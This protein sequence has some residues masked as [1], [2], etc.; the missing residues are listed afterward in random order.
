MLRTHQALIK[1]ENSSKTNVSIGDIIRSKVKEIGFDASKAEQL[2]EEL[3]P[4]EQSSGYFN[5]I[6][7]LFQR[8]S[9]LIIYQNG[10][11]IRNVIQLLC[12]YYF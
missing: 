4:L 10:L 3:K 5:G 9:H 11:I 12:L 6:R 8:D 1:T 7:W 2:E